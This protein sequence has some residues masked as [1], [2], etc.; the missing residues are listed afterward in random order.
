LIEKTKEGGKKMSNFTTY[1]KELY[2]AIANKAEEV[3]LKPN[4][5]YSY[6]GIVNGCKVKD[7]LSGTTKT[8]YAVSQ[9]TWRGFRTTPNSIYGPKVIFT[10]YFT[11]NKQTILSALESINSVEELN[12]LEDEICNDIKNNLIGNIKAEQLGSYN[13]IRK[14]VD[15]Y[16]EHIV[17]MCSEI[18]SENRIKLCKLL[19]LPLDS[20][21]FRSPYIF[22]RSELRHCGIS[23]NATFK[24]V[25]DSKIYAKLQD[26]LSKKAADISDTIGKEFYRIYFDLLWNDRYKKPGKNLFE[27]NF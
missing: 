5:L 15:L 10:G 18:S 4:P 6:E 3:F 2:T 7:P 13:K 22:D 11:K 20:Q 12:S 27:T 16:I 9:N 21:I 8:M 24:D 23:E 17:S 26:S 19:F 25:Q 14:P 1:E